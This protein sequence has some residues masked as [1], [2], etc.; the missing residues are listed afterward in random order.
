MRIKKMNLKANCDYPDQPTPIFS[1]P[2]SATQ[3]QHLLDRCSVGKC[4]PINLIGDAWVLNGG[5]VRFLIL[6][7]S[8]K[9][10]HL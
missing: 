5:G 4:Q 10:S 6:L 1:L 8:K 2:P 9:A 7:F 3:N